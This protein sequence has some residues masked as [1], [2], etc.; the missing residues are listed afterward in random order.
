MD[1]HG[2]GEESEDRH[3]EISIEERATV[4][5]V[6]GQAGME[7]DIDMQ[8]MFEKML[9]TRRDTRRLTVAEARKVLF[10]Q[11]AEKL[12]DKAADLVDDKTGHKHSGQIDSAADKAKDLVDDLDTSDEKKKK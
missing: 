10:N 7:M 4:V 5:G 6:L 9:P 8:N 3:V 2:I 12:I 1:Q 11:E